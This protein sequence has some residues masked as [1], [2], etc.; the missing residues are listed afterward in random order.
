M[1]R[2]MKPFQRLAGS[3]I[4]PRHANPEILAAAQAAVAGLKPAVAVTGASRG[5]GFALAEHFAKEGHDVALIARTSSDL[6]A[7]AARIRSRATPAGVL[8]L[9]LDITQ[10]GAAARLDEWLRAAGYYVDVLVNNA[11]IGL[12]GPFAQSGP[13]ALERLVTLNVTAPTLLMVRFLPEM[14]ARQRGGILN[15]GSLGGA[16]PGPGQAAYYASKAYLQ[17]LSE[18]AAAECSGAGV[19][20]STLLPGPV[21]TGFHASMGAESSLY[22]QLL[23]SLSPQHVARAG[24]RGFRIGQRVIVPGLFNKLL[25]IAIRA[26]PHPLTVPFVKILLNKTDP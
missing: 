20:I 24:Y 21:D 12:A 14:L 22:R 11:G 5:I 4:A 18:A 23:P 8:T 16:V 3:W 26:L 9:S 6:D 7:A 2:L 13:A 1:T 17:S 19:R 10:A 15:V 25:Y